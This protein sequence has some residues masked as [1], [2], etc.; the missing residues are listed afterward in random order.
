MSKIDKIKQIQRLLNSKQ[1]RIRAG[2]YPE[3]YKFNE[4]NRVRW[5]CECPSNI[6]RDLSIICPSRDDAIFILDFI[7]SEEDKID[8][9][10]KKK[11]IIYEEEIEDIEI[12]A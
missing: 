4:P 6:E 10:A 2:Y 9:K 3:P 1:H 11:I 5:V 7:C 8:K 12:P